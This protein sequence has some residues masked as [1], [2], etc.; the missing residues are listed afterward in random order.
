M[1]EEKR[2]QMAEAR[3]NAEG[4]PDEQ[5]ETVLAALLKGV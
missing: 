1:S 3:R 5:A 4:M 2:E